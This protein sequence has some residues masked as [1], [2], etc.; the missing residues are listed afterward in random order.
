MLSSLKYEHGI[1]YIK[2]FILSPFSY[3][4]FLNSN[5][6]CARRKWLKSQDSRYSRGLCF[7]TRL[8]LTLCD[9]VINC[10]PPGF[11]AHGILQARTLEWVAMLSSSG[12]SW[13]ILQGLNSWLLWLLH[14]RRILYCWATVERIWSLENWRKRMVLTDMRVRFVPLAL[15]P[16]FWEEI[17]WH[18]AKGM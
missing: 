18:L 5:D 1:L 4:L 17:E 7:A 15:T 9:P 13:S 3:F 2:H 14:C 8:C 10:S 6:S 16:S 11:S 12:S